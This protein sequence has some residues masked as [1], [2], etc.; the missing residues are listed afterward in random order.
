MGNVPDFCRNISLTTNETSYELL[1][2]CW[3][4]KWIADFLRKSLPLVI[5]PV[6]LICNF[7]S[8]IALRSRHMRGTSTAFFMLALS[9]LDPLVLLTKNLVYFP[10][11]VAAHGILCKTLY[12]LIYVLGY[13]NVW[14]LVIMTAD[15]FFAVWF[16]L[17]VSDFCTIDRAKHVCI[18]LPAMT[19]IISFH[20]FWTIDSLKHPND[21]KQRFCYYD[22]S[23][24]RSIQRIWRYVDFVIWCFLPF[25]LIL[26][27]SVLIIYKLRQNRQGSNKN[28]LKMLKTNSKNER[29]VSRNRLSKLQHQ[30]KRTE[31]QDI[32]MRSNQKIEVIRSRHR[33]I[34]LMLLA[35]AVVFLLLTLP[36]SIYFVLDLTYGFNKLPTE[37]DYYQWLRYRR[38]TILTVIMFQLSDLQHAT[39]F[40]LY[41]LTSDKFRRSVIRICVS[42]IPILSSLIPCCCQDK[43]RSSTASLPGHYSSQ[44]HDKGP[45]TFRTSVSERSSI[46]ISSN[47]L[48]SRQMQQPFYKYSSVSSKPVTTA[49]SNST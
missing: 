11:F 7:L 42:T 28:I 4:E 35:V 46:H 22:I 43:G 14:I 48:S 32:E 19:S 30:K 6:S 20:H 24:Y 27:L 21:P 29:I 47:R 33:H 36:N 41:L 8:F 31:N 13:T 25:I 15:K 37:N 23:R 17:K 12:F 34:T 39:N 10:T 49:A 45:I 44:R 5:L 9:V 3:S 2:E 16:P 18:F 38:L 40:F 26:T 1:S